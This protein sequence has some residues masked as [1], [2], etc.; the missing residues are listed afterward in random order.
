MLSSSNTKQKLSHST[1]VLNI[2]KGNYSEMKGIVSN[3]LLDQSIV[4][5]ECR[6]YIYV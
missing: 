4:P 3:V 2:G 6:R 5:S 1:F